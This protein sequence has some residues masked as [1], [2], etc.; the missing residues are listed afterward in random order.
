[1]SNTKSHNRGHGITIRRATPGDAA[2]LQRLFDL[3]GRRLSSEPVLVAELDG[4]IEAA[5]TLTGSE[6][7]ANPFLPT[8]H[9]VE[10]LRAQALHALAGA[11][12]AR[13]GRFLRRAP[14]PA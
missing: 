11:R 6:S 5:I 12:S 10:M 2:A 4:T 1:M 13:D 7:V 3:E 8:A 9:L 14:H